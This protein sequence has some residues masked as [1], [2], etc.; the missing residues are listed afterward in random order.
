MAAGFSSP[1]PLSSSG[2]DGTATPPTVR[3]PRTGPSPPLAR[4]SDIMAIAEAE[5][6]GNGETGPSKE[7]R[8]RLRPRVT[9]ARAKKSPRPSLPSSSRSIL[10][11]MLI[12]VVVVV[13]VV[14]ADDPFPSDGLLVEDPSSSSSTLP[15][16]HPSRPPAPLL[17]SAGRT[18][19]TVSVRPDPGDEYYNGALSLLRTGSVHGGREGGLGER[20]SAPTDGLHDSDA[21]ATAG[22]GRIGGYE[23]QAEGRRRRTMGGGGGGG[24]IEGGE[25]TWGTTDDVD[26]IVATPSSLAG[27][28]ATATLTGLEPGTGHR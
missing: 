24:E 7:S 1:S 14:V 22:V 21:D 11:S 16:P 25:G 15:P 23:L 2:G 13:F 26:V 8:S 27:G 19:L 18:Y 9:A 20:R 12:A 6:G 4:Y 17:S 28:M 3:S 10:I 5:A